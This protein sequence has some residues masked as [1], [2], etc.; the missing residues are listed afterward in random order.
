[1]N[2]SDGN[3]NI[4]NEFD[5][6]LVHKKRLLCAYDEG[7][8]PFRNW[9]NLR[10]LTSCTQLVGELVEVNRLSAF[11]SARTDKASQIHWRWA[12]GTP[13]ERVRPPRRCAGSAP[14]SSGVRP[15]PAGRRSWLPGLA[16]GRNDIGPCRHQ[17]GL[18]SAILRRAASMA[19]SWVALSNLKIQAPVILMSQNR[20]AARDRLAASLDYEI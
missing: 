16:F 18:T 17:F 2:L 10:H 7:D 19:A 9:R 14:V 4:L 1:M 12:M 5:A 8:L 20:Q 3:Q 6:S 15:R 13:S 11:S